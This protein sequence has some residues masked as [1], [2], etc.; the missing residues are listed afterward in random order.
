MKKMKKLLLLIISGIFLLLSGFL[1]L[2][3]AQ[4]TLQTALELSKGNK[5]RY[6]KPGKKAV[7]R[8]EGQKYKIW[9]DSISPDK[10]FTKAD[11]F[12]ISNIN[13][14]SIKFKGTQI[15]GSIVGTAGVLFTGL[16][17]Y[18]I[19][20]G[21]QSNTLGGAFAVVFGIV[22]DI[23]GVPVAAIGTS[24]FFIGKKYKRTKGWDFKAV[25][26]E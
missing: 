18:A 11:S 6:V 21:L 12:K 20:S 3:S 4:N 19:I 25:Q 9:I 22:I 7:I 8:Y 26:M 24:I 13:T 1:N 10:I 15:T 16:G 14:I 2:I 5:I 23:I 17:T